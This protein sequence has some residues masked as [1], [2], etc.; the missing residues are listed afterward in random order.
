MLYLPDYFRYIEVLVARFVSPFSPYLQ[1]KCKLAI[2]R[3]Q[4]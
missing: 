2:Y 3:A 1:C 4:A